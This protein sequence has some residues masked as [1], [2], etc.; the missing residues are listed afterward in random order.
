MSIPLARSRK[1][2]TFEKNMQ[3]IKATATNTME[4]ISSQTGIPVHTMAK[5]KAQLTNRKTTSPPMKSLSMGGGGRKSNFPHAK[6]I[7]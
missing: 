2:C 6:V 5:W 3:I 4:S 7:L 1:R